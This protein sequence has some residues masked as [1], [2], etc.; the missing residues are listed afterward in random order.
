MGRKVSYVPLQWKKVET[1]WIVII[2]II[3]IMNSFQK[4]SEQKRIEERELLQ[5]HLFL[6]FFIQWKLESFFLYKNYTI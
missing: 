4:P 6:A 5:L 3:M 1:G 2:M